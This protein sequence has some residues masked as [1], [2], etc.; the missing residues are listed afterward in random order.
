M[1]GQYESIVEEDGMFACVF[2]RVYAKFWN[3][4]AESVLSPSLI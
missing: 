2:W 1:L 4:T 3:Q